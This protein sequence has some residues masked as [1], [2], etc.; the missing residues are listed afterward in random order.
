MLIMIRT[1]VLTKPELSVSVSL[2]K[3]YGTISQP[4][5]PACCPSVGLVQHITGL[6]L[7]RPSYPFTS[8]QDYSVHCPV[9]RWDV[10]YYSA[11]D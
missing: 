3:P 7:S 11:L 10:I 8:R 2:I 5:A 4:P 6:T 1:T 9:L